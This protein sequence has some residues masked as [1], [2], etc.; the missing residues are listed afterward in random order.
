MSPSWSDQLT[1]PGLI[2]LGLDLLGLAV[3]VVYHLY[4]GHVFRRHPER[5]YRGHS[6]RL[7]RVWVEVMRERGAD[8][9]GVQ[10][11]RNW[12]MSATLLGSTSILIGLGV[13]HVAFAGLDVTS[14]AAALS[15]FPPLPDAVVRLKLLVLGVMFFAAFHDFSLSLRYYNHAGFLINLPD[16]AI[17]GPSAI[18]G[19]TATLN[20]AGGH[21]NRGTRKL[22]LSAP[23]ALWLIGPAWFFAGAVAI[24]LMLRRFDFRDEPQ[25][26]ELGR[27]EGPG[28]T[29]PGAGCAPA[30]PG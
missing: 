17:P 16:S 10:T 23:F 13:V 14:L 8:I 22:L 20:R 1:T 2:A 5:T 25:A 6:N 19:V 21:Y 9:L 18:D 3:L 4:L 27:P 7:R 24:T 12:V 28:I 26:W 30:D 15:P 11:L 29:G